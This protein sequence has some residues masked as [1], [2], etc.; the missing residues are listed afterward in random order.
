MAE[1]HSLFNAFIMDKL[2]QPANP[3]NACFPL[4]EPY[5]PYILND[6][7]YWREP[8]SWVSSLI[9]LNIFNNR[10]NTK[11]LRGWGEAGRVSWQTRDEVFYIPYYSFILLVSCGL[12]YYIN[13]SNPALSFLYAKNKSTPSNFLHNNYIVEQM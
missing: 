4:S 2:I 13:S 9:T 3:V 8:N 12:H 7:F 10:H 5:T 1:N 6:S 11:Q